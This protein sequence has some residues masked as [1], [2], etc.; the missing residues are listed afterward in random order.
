V[1]GII[2]SLTEARTAD[3]RTESKCDEMS[4]DSAPSCLML[5]ACLHFRFILYLKNKLPF[6]F[7]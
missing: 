4:S 5:L 6:V 3:L 2:R 1:G 7:A